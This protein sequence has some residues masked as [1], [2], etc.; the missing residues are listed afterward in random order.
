M[1][2]RYLIYGDLKFT[3]SLAIHKYYSDKCQIKKTKNKQGTRN[4]PDSSDDSKSDEGIKKEVR[5]L[6]SSVF[7]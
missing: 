3:E 6:T 1:N 7:R 4:N 5:K 2:I